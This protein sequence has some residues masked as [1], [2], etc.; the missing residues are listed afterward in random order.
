MRNLCLW[1]FY[2]VFFFVVACDSSW[3]FISPI[4]TGDE[5]KWQMEANRWNEIQ[6]LEAIELTPF[7]KEIKGML[8]APKYKKFA[9]D[10]QVFVSAT[11][12]DPSYRKANIWIEVQYLEPTPTPFPKEFHYYLSSKDGKF[13]KNLQLF[14]GKGTYQVSIYLS[15]RRKKDRYHLFA[16]FS[17]INTNPTYRREIAYSVQAEKAGLKLSEPQTG[18]SEKKEQFSLQGT[19]TTKLNQP[20][21][22]VQVKKEEQVWK[23]T[24]PV[25]N[26]RFSEVI[27][28]PF[29]KGFYEV[30]VLLPSDKES[31][32]VEG[33]TLYVHN[34][35]ERKRTP[36]QY[37]PLYE[38]RGI[39]LTYPRSG[40]DLAEE[41]YRI[42][43]LIDPAA[44]YARQTPFIVVQTSKGKD[45]ATY[46][47]PVH[48]FRFDE[49]VPLRFGSGT[50]QITVFV[51]D[52]SE[53]NRD[54]FRFYAV[55]R[56][57]IMSTVKKDLRNLLP[58]RG[59]PSDN[60]TIRN[61]AEEIARGKK[62]PKEKAKAIFRF[63]ARTL[64]YDVQKFR[65]NSFEWDD[66]A[67]KSLQKR[68][69]VCQDYVFLTIAL[70]RSLEIPA[71]FIDGIAEGQRHAWV[72]VWIGDR[73]LVMDPTW[74][75]GYLDPNG[76]F[77]K[78]YNPYY[79]D[80]PPAE[81]R[82]T[83]KRIGVVY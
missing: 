57:E 83:H 43:G 27:P 50:Y 14:A 10:S 2:I 21:L 38:Q 56:F 44:P 67:L 11:I 46:F 3:S 33:A 79:F 37:S 8:T 36:I 13:E 82:K 54:Y 65:T 51:P 40:G 16:Q 66:G 12:Q 61:L 41:F 22:L 29:G 69:G 23:W 48:H 25:R 70:L 47:L 34:I 17:V 31:Y 45:E 15:D 64:T 5:A 20:N 49:Q 68:S 52:I 1:C 75:S 76:R 30:Q 71:R 74:G 62:T 59:I 18:Y 4:E 55:A 32:Y 39:Y 28:L 7:A 42:A 24:I 73:W 35:S 60:P 26:H 9:V 6:K 19:V 81:F 77:V 72:E 53:N 80:P 63:V 58:S 78:Q